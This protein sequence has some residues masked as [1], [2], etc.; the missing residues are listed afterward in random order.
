MAYYIRLS[1]DQSHEWQVPGGA[2]GKSTNPNIH[3][4]RFGFGF[5]E[6]CFNARRFKDENGN[7]AHF[8]YLQ[9]FCRADA[10]DEKEDLVLYTLEKNAP[11]PAN[12][13]IVARIKAG[14]WR[15]MDHSRYQVLSTI[16]NAAINQMNAELGV[17]Y[18]QG[19][20]RDGLNLGDLAN[21]FNEQ[22]NC[23][24]WYGQT[25]DTYRLWNIEFLKPVKVLMQRVNENTPCP[26]WHVN[27]LKMF[28]LYNNNKFNHKNCK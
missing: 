14:T 7:M 25:S 1:Y 24:D 20:I 2:Q 18:Q 12:R 6:W 11:H 27:I 17:A 19:I 22:R 9:A 13:Y 3:E 10:P 16:N 5:E 8:A 23:Q 28:N 21:R 15:F 4:H 26:D